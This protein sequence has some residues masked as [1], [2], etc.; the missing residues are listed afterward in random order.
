MNRDMMDDPLYNDPQ[1]I[2]PYFTYSGLTIEQEKDARAKIFNKLPEA[3]LALDGVGAIAIVNE[4]MELLSGYAAMDLIGR[5]VEMLIPERFHKDHEKFRHLF[6]I[7]P[8]V[9]EMAGGKILPL[10]HRTGEEIPVII[11]LS[12]VL[13][14]GVGVLPIIAIRRAP[15]E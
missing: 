4:Q 12:S 8:A 3:I 11:W 15:D 2:L 7:K 14:G 5:P 10:L 9:R 6:C 1:E 13:V